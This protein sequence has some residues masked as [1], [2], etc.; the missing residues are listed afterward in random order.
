MSKEMVKYREPYK[1]IKCGQELVFLKNRNG[2]LIDYKRLIYK[3]ANTAI[4][5][6]NYLKDKHI[7]GMKCLNCQKTF[8]IDWTHGLPQQLDDDT[9]NAILRG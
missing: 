2:M 9:L 1:C 4:E 8:I 3:N 7:T 6:K 5:V